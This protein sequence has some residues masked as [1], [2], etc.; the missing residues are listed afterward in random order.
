MKEKS[1]IYLDIKVHP[2]SR[3]QKI[4]KIDSTAYKVHVLAPPTKGEANK[5]V[6]K[7]IAAHFDLPVTLVQIIR[8][9]SS[10][11]KVVAIQ[12]KVQDIR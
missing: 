11:N 10:R 6:V 9:H 3:R 4:T 1:R 2:R 8:G 12:K 5:E 7:I